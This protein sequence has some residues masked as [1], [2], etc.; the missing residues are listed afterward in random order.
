M[1]PNELAEALLDALAEQG[2]SATVGAAVQY[3]QKIALTGPDGIPLGNLVI[4][5]GKAGPKLVDT[6]VRPAGRGLLPTV[7]A[8]WQ[9]VRASHVEAPTTS[10]SDRVEISRYAAQLAQ[11]AAR[12]QRYGGQSGLS[13]DSL[14]EAILE[15]ARRVDRPLPGAGENDGWQAW[16]TFARQVAEEYGS[17]DRGVEVGR[18]LEGSADT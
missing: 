9:A 18:G 3:G 15:L 8:A 12:A 6:E 7:H 1:A 10:P 17:D 2:I 16:A 14:R 5:V 4:Y 11:L 13:W